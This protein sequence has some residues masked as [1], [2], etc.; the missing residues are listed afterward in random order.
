M[1]ANKL[2]EVLRATLDPSQREEAEKQLEIVHKIIGFAPILLQVVMEESIDMPV[3]QAGV[4]YLKNMCTQFWQDREAENPGDPVPFN[5]HEQDRLTIRNN[6]IE[7]VIHA[8]EPIRVQLCVCISTM[9][10]H[11]YPGRW[12]NFP[13]KVG[14]YIQSDNHATWMGA[15]MSLYQMVKVYEYKRSEER[16]ILDEG[17]RHLLPLCYQ[18]GTQLLPDPSE[19]SVLLQK[20]ILKI[21]YAYIQNHL[22]LDFVSKEVFTLWMELIRQIVDR[23]V[24]EQT[25]QI[26]ED[27]R[28]ELAWWKVK[29]WAV[30]ILSR[31]FERYGS[32][33]NV[34]KDYNQ[35]AEWYLK[36]FSG[37]VMQVLLKVLDQYRQKMYVAPRVLQQSL[38]FLN[39]GVSHA[40]AW[41]FMKPHIQLVIQEVIFP[42]M[43]H[44]DSDEELWESDPQEY[45]RLKYDVFED[46]LSP[47]IAAQ[48]LFYSCASKRKE[49]LQKSMGFCMQLMTSGNTEPRQK[50][51]AL[52][53]IGAVAEVL[54][55]RKIY[56]DQAEMMLVSHVYPEFVSPHGFLRARA[57]WVLRVF[58]E[59]RFK[60]ESHLYQA[61]ECTKTCMCNDKELPVRVEAAI[62]LQMLISDQ[63]KAK[64]YMKPHV[65]TV[66]LELLHIIRET[67]ND[68]LTGTMQRLV[69]TYVEEVTPIA[70]EMMSHLATTFSQVLETDSDGS[71]EKAITALGILNTMETILT[72][73]EEHKDI[74]LQ[75]EGLVLNIVGVVMQRQLSDFYEEVLSLIYSLTSAHVTVHMW[76]VFGMLYDM[77]Q[78]DGVD[79]FTDMMPALHNYIT[80]DTPTFLSNPKHLEAIYNMC[81]QVLAAD[82]GEDAECHAAKLLEVILLQC[83]GQVN[84][85]VR[86]FV[87]LVLERLTRE[88]VTSE[89]RT[90]CLQVVIAALYYNTPLLLET[91]KTLKMEN[92]QGSVMQQF[93]K[94]W[95]HDVDCF[96]GLHDRKISVLGLCNLLTMVEA[97]RP[98]EVSEIGAQILP[99]ALI[100]F[101]GLKRAYETRAENEN[102]DDE[103]DG[104]DEDADY[105]QEALASDEDEVDEEGQQYL[106]KLEKSVNNDDESSDDDSLDDEAEETALE[107]YQTPLDDDNCLVDEYIIFKQILQGLQSVDPGWY[108]LVTSTL[109]PEQTKQLEDVFKLAEQRKAA[110]ESK[111]IEES[112]GYSFSDPTVPQTFNF[113]QIG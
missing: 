39:Q 75:L 112:G 54:L 59:L 51:G 45:I 89:L 43:C 111:K 18:R 4:V 24:P 49:V 15:F 5:I 50:D 109:T 16:T 1:D 87:E 96:L 46:F 70:V 25:N 101:S 28:P 10:K 84:S 94:Q 47:V 82:V 67:E 11:D 66:I 77:F 69:C 12:P 55:K 93:L 33:G 78:K 58:S 22:P 65:K 30:H 17:M 108:A 9:I 32:P 13:E 48:T 72:V 110:A 19:A 92:V 3:R 63:E 29:K 73:M 23:P 74:M 88:V 107:S 113:G 36:A 57:C 41:K 83:P 26:D 60:Q 79:Y 95:I 53:M 62:A 80:V 34:T 90:M 68:D 7:A 97:N 102:S 71:E 2:I 85:I 91:L 20:Q 76:Q 81:K 103:D 64:Q 52:H 14:F 98:A 100:L 86:P 31:S 27:D 106:E 38:N 35:F 61:L 104:D 40:F 8:P 99:A 6:I 44:N 42:L 105:E 56:K 37:G 21:F